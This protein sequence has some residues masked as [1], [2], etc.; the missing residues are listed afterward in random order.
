[1]KPLL[2]AGGV[3]I[4]IILGLM[5]G[6]FLT[7]AI[8]GDVTHTL[9]FTLNHALAGGIGG[10]VALG[11]LIN[12]QRFRNAGEAGA[13]FGIAAGVGEFA[14]A[15]LPWI[16]YSYSRPACTTATQVCPLGS[17]DLLRLSLTTG[18]FALALFT[19]GGASL[20][21]LIA[22]VRSAVHRE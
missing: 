22:A 7:Y 9:P 14:V 6:P 10:V 18:L 4:A 16:G 11:A 13:I 3:T 1:M 5:A 20:A 21:M 8:A 12:A 15:V 19:I 2:H 17:S